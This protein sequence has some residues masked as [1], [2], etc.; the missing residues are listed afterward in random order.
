MKTPYLT[1][2]QCIDRTIEYLDKGKTKII[3]VQFC[4]LGKTEL[5]AW[6]SKEI[7]G[8]ILFVVHKNSILNQAAK[9]Y[10]EL[11][12]NRSFGFFN[13]DD[14]KTNK[15][16]T[17]AT[18]QT[19]S[20][21]N[22]LAKFSEDYFELIIIDECHHMATKSYDKLLEHFNNRYL[23]GFTAT[24]DRA[25]RKP[26]LDLFEEKVG[27]FDED[28][29]DKS[30]RMGI[31]MGYLSP[32]R[33]FALND[34]IDYKKI[35]HNGYRYNKKNLDKELIIK[36]R[37]DLVVKKWMEMARGKKTI[38]FCNSVKHAK[39]ME[40]HFGKFGV[41]AVTLSYKAGKN[42]QKVI[43]KQF[44][45]GVFDVILT[46]DLYI[47]GVDFP[48]CECVMFLR[49][50]ESERI[51]TQQL[52]RVMRISEGKQYGMVM[53]FVGNQNT[54]YNRQKWIKK[55]LVDK[56]KGLSY[57]KDYKPIIYYDPLIEIKIDA[58]VVDI[59]KSKP[60]LKTLEDAIK[61]FKKK[62]GN[63]IIE[64][65]RLYKENLWM[66][67]QFKKYNLLDR[68]C[69]PSK[70][71]TTNIKD[72]INNYNRIY[73]N[74]KP[75]RRKLC[76]E[77][78]R[79]YSTFKKHNLLDKYC[80][81]SKMKDIVFYKEEF[82]KIYGNAKPGRRQLYDENSMMY[83]SF[84]RS[85]LLDKYCKPNKLRSVQDAITEFKKIYGN[86][87]PHRSQVTKENQ[88]IIFHF[89][90]HN[91]LDKYCLPSHIGKSISK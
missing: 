52:G 13:S 28:G 65:Q 68:Y 2:Q 7:K 47:E 32:L 37:N 36:K 76:Y 21:E 85:G 26:I 46:V 29:N 22:N 51:F 49:P 54:A 61:E 40:L 24:P 15:E 42:L 87:K 73:K 18:I 62:Y 79:I 30:L 44:R 78:S 50:T 83:S 58:E 81:P 9:T 63:K 27:F 74:T 86:K 1:Q 35:L 88:W 72:E 10:K 38:A 67:R 55:L 41:N 53:D 80:Q 84:Q 82:K 4:G 66:V 34:N 17:F 77:N 64:R 6:I 8:N 91:L 16:V 14:K 25:D 20:K 60:E 90:K 45:Q 89:R 43:E 5:G 11:I 75:G 59:F 48:E 69:K 19:L 56:E 33:Y 71:G 70:T 12:P 57:P 39:E 3:N 31:E 23:F